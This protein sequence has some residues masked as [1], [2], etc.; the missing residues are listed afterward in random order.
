MESRDCTELL[1][2][3]LIV[4]IRVRVENT[5]ETVNISHSNI[6]LDSSP[7]AK[8]LKAKINK[9]DLIKLKSFCIAKEIINKMKR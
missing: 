6:F 9:W 4:M 3:S 2:L 1:D 5:C 8:E 7:K